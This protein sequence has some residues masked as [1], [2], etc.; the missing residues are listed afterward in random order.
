LNLD[1]TVRAESLD[2]EAMLALSEIVRPAMGD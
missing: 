2:V 1:G